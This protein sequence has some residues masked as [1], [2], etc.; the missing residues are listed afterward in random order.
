MIFSSYNELP[1]AYV[2]TWEV[3]LLKNKK[4]AVLMN[5]GALIIPIIMIVIF[6]ILSNWNFEI[7]VFMTL[8]ILILGL[9]STTIIHEL[10]HG[11]F[12]KLGTKEKL[13]FKLSLF[14]ASASVPTAYFRKW[15]YLI[16]G[17]APFVIL[18]SILIVVCI[19]LKNTEWL[20]GVYV[21][22]SVHTGGCIGDFFISI[23]LIG[24]PKSVL[25][26]DTGTGMTFYNKVEEN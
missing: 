10:I 24:E 8:L 22:L 13:K 1:N 6:L 4:M 12:F 5:V 21:L 7:D 2:K 3:D 18:D 11:L 23:K 16:V 25:I 14:F 20:F 26:H 15:H 17:L 9:V 19:L